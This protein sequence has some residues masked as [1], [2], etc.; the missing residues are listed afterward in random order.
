MV[1]KQLRLVVV[2]LVI[3]NG[4]VLMAFVALVVRRVVAFR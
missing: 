1:L 2:L 3:L 4:L